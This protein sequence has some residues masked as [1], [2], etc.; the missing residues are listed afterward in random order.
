MNAQTAE[1]TELP[2]PADISNVEAEAF[3]LGCMMT[4][5][6]AIDRVADILRAEDFR[7]PLHGRIFETLV[8]QASL[9]RG[10]S[11]IAIKGM[12]EG[13]QDLADLGGASYLAKLTGD[14]S[15]GVL[16]ER[17][18]A[19]QI[20]DLADRRRMRAGLLEAVAKC[21]D[22]NAPLLEIASCAD[23]AVSARAETGLV[24]ADAADCVASFMAEM[25]DDS[26]GV[27][28]VNIPAMD[29][30]LGG[31]R[32]KSLTILGGRPGMGK[33]AVACS[34]ARGAANNGHGVLFVTLEMAKEELIGRMIA[35]ALFDNEK[36]R[37][38]YSVLR[39]RPNHWERQQIEMAGNYLSSLPLTVVDTRASMGGFPRAKAP[40]A[41]TRS[42]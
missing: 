15:I 33:T 38:P 19:R 37:V 25:D 24:E 39:G 40:L 16:D 12:F 8:H 35:E 20:I 6:A 36:Q 28:C 26:T 10:T 1:I 17:E 7:H 4:N 42:P 21:S 5:R 41:T 11:P 13:D 22:L 31:P 14:N 27:R 3:L 29:D 30:L 9:G 2:P 34:Y 32:P 18:F 23:A